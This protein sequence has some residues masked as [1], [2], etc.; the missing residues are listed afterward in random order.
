M[1]NVAAVLG[2]AL[3]LYGPAHVLAY[4]GPGIGLGT[5]AVAVALLLGVVLLLTGLV[6][7]PLKRLARSRTVDAA[8]GSRTD[9]SE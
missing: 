2:E 7:Y 3:G 4:I 5:I 8:S 1:M 6:W 9:H